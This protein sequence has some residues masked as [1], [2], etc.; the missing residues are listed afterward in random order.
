MK[1]QLEVYNETFQTNTKV[2]IY[3]QDGGEIF[4]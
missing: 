1:T 4:D 2:K 3:E